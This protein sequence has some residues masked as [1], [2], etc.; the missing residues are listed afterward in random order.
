MEGYDRMN[1]QTGMA[2]L[3][4]VAIGVNA[5]LIGLLVGPSD[6]QTAV[7]QSA[8][9]TNGF[10]M[11]VGVLQGKGQSEALYILDTTNKK[12]AVYFMNNARMEVLGIRD[13]TYDLIPEAWSPKSGDQNP[14]PKQMKDMVK[15]G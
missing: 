5:I 13:L 10:L 15:G 7:G 11:T 14:T 12:L 3:L 4:G 2:L 1:R 6:S 8:N 9:G